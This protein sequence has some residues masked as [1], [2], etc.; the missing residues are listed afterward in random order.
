[1]RPGP[2]KVI[3]QDGMNRCVEMWSASRGRERAGDGVLLKERVV[4]FRIF[5]GCH[6]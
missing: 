5:K 4:F 2:C 6:D 1:M 3:G